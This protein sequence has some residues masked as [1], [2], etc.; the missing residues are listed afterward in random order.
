MLQRSCHFYCHINKCT[1]AVKSSS[2]FI[3]P[4][5]AKKIYDICKFQIF[6]KITIFHNILNIKRRLRLDCIR[7]FQ[8]A[9]SQGYIIL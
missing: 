2:I 1:T 8:R 6:K 9:T 7:H 5:L 3:Q 4:I